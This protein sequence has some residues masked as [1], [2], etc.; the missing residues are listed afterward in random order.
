MATTATIPDCHTGPATAFLG[1]ALAKSIMKAAAVIMTIW[2]MMFMP[3]G[4][5]TGEPSSATLPL[6]NVGRMSKPMIC[7]SE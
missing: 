4:F 7:M 6:S 2:M 5:M 3:M 1:L